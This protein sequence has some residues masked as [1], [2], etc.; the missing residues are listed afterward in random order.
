MPSPLQ[1]HYE[2]N[3]ATLRKYHLSIWQYLQ[4]T[5][6]A[7][8][9]VFITAEDGITNLRLTKEDGRVVFLVEGTS[10]EEEALSYLHLVPQGSQGVVIFVGLGL[11]TIP[12][13]IFTQRP[14]LQYLLVFEP[15][16]DIFNQALTATDLSALLADPKVILQVGP[17]AD[18]ESAVQQASRAIQLE[19]THILRHLPS[20]AYDEKKY[21]DT[22]DRMF[23]VINRLNVAGSTNVKMGLDFLQNRLKNITTTP[24]NRLAENLRGCMKGIPAILVG[25]G[26]SL[27]KNIDL[28]VQAQ[29]K[30]IIFAVDSTFP[31]LVA[32]HLTPHFLSAIDP[33]EV[34]FEKVADYCGHASDTS[35]L[36]LSHVTPNVPKTFPA[37][38]VFWCYSSSPLDAWINAS[39]GGTITTGDVQTVAHLNLAVAILM[40][41]SPI[42]FIGQDLSYPTDKSHAAHTVLTSDELMEER[43]KKADDM[44]WVKGNNG[45]LVPTDRALRGMTLHFEE[46]LKAHPN[47]YINATEGG[48]YI[49]GTEVMPLRKALTEYCA[50]SHPIDALINTAI[51]DTASPEFDLFVEKGQKKLAE[52]NELTRLLEKN[53]INIKQLQQQLPTI[54]KKIPAVPGYD[55]LPADIRKKLLE[56]DKLSKRIDGKNEVWIALQDVTMEGLKESERLQ[57]AINRLEKQPGNYMQCLAKKIDRL[58][59]VNKTHRRAVAAF[60]ENL[61]Q[62]VTLLQQELTLGTEKN[63]PEKI[64]ALANLHLAANNHVLAKYFLKQAAEFLPASPEI[65]FHLGCI[66]AYQ[67]DYQQAENFFAQATQEDGSTGHNFSARIERFRLEQGDIFIAYAEVYKE[68]GRDTYRNL[69]LKGLRICPTHRAL[70][71][72]IRACAEEDLASA[73]KALNEGGP[74]GRLALAEKWHTLVNDNQDLQHFLGD[75][76]RAE[77]LHAFGRLKAFSHDYQQAF[78][79]LRQAL[80]I[81]PDNPE[82]HTTLTSTMFE[83]GNFSEGINHLRQAVEI[84]RSYASHWEELGD[85]LCAAGQEEDAIA[86]YEQCFLA[87]NERHSLL[88]K[89]G[90]CYLSMGNTAAATEAYRLYQGQTLK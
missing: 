59:F 48:A 53:L 37:K 47:R 25:G 84:D 1:T 49:E 41:C 61:Q 2:K 16:L 89:M 20:F 87:L 54:A 33:D 27:D 29:D 43:L 75:K 34:I 66:A 26:P 32:H 9:G 24:H 62:A 79:S 30:A 57:H 82:I 7:P 8:K 11:G 78:L 38:Q 35:L 42:I 73:Q 17:V 85:V 68:F 40:G 12:S 14:E 36:C 70:H 4:Q 58:A 5:P 80:A 15:D 44:L 63:D 13:L 72:R 31:A 67:R 23:S 22:N 21:L 64:L 74:D 71:E 69:L 51:A 86:A 45:D 81:T 18:M 83:L 6:I 28:L 52:L 19:H 65:N 3:I 50:G 10:P 56:T 39:L 90:D 77:I 60:K 88:K 46:I 55:R 76:L